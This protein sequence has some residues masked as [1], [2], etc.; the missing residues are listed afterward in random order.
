MESISFDE[1]ETGVCD[2]GG[3]LAVHFESLVNFLNLRVEYLDLNG[4]YC[5][6]RWVTLINPCM[7]ISCPTHGNGCEGWNLRTMTMAFASL[8]RDIS[9]RRP[10]AML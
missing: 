6:A 3:A 4:N 9:E 1:S 5:I 10:T 2:Q 8:A 7:F